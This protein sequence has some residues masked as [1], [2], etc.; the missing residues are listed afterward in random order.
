MKDTLSLLRELLG[1]VKHGLSESDRK[2]AYDYA[3]W[4]FNG[5]GIGGLPVDSLGDIYSLQTKA[6][7]QFYCLE[8]FA[9]LEGEADAKELGLVKGS[10]PEGWSRQ[11]SDLHETNFTSD[12]RKAIAQRSSRW[13]R[14]QLAELL[15]QTQ[16]E[17]DAFEPFTCIYVN[18]QPETFLKRLEGLVAYKTFY[19]QLADV[20]ESG[21]NQADTGQ[22]GP[23]FNSLGAC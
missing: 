12:D 1:P 19:E 9:S 3:E 13:R 16:A 2:A 8:Y 7:I 17:D 22:A 5:K 10:S 15:M 4:L 6:H 20:L 14:Q 11:L 21:K 18:Y 23:R